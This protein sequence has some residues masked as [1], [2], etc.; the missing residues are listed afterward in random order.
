MDV[1]VVVVAV[2]LVMSIKKFACHGVGERG[3]DVTATVFYKVQVSRMS[4]AIH[5][6]VGTLF[7][8]VYSDYR[9]PLR[10]HGQHIR[11]SDKRPPLTSL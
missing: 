10:H 1:V 5:T 8:R 2:V 6:L 11:R 7:S 4:P 9:H 3:N